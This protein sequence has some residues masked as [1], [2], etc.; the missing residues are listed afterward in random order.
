MSYYL[1]DNIVIEDEQ[2]FHINKNG[3]KNKIK[4]YNWHHILKEYGWEKIPKKWI[5]KLNK[6]S[7]LYEKNSLYGVLDCE[8]DGDCFF[9]CISTSLNE[10]NNY[11]TQY[12]SSDIRKMLSESITDDQFETLLSTYKIMM[13]A[14]DFD[15]DWDPYRINSKEEF[16]GELLECGHNYWGDHLL[17]QLLINLLEVNIFILT[18]NSE[19]NEYSVYNTLNEYNKNHDSICL[20]YED[21]CH[22]KLIGYYDGNRM[23]SHF[24]DNNLPLEIKKIYGILR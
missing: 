18:S 9:H 15:E 11:L 3:D 1:T 20:L 6:Q 23:I 8:H 2:M 22:F 24:K 14:G 21:G 13:D 16:Q 5:Q 19:M 17:M 4:K 10:K 7:E 12:D